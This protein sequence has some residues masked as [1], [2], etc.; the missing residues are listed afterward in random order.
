MVSSLQFEAVKKKHPD[1]VV[2]WGEEQ[3]KNRIRIY[4]PQI[5]PHLGTFNTGNNS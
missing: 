2:R 1:A 4:M 3:E 5:W